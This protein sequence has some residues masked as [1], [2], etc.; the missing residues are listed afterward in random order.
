M[1]ATLL[2]L[3]GR[4]APVGDPSPSLYGSASASSPQSNEAFFFDISRWSSGR[5][6][7]QEADLNAAHAAA[8]EG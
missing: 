1:C 5:L 3:E 6:S 4:D 8:P 2:Q 7:R